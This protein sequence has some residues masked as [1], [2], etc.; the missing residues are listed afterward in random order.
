DKERGVAYGADGGEEK[1]ESEIGKLFAAQAEADKKAEI[2]SI[3]N[4]EYSRITGAQGSRGVSFYYF[5]SAFLVLFIIFMAY[6]ISQVANEKLSSG[7]PGGYFNAPYEPEG[8]AG[9]NYSAAGKYLDPLSALAF[10]ALE[11]AAIFV[12]IIILRFLLSCVFFK[13]GALNKKINIL[14]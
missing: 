1:F 7:G 9:D 8:D 6:N 3:R 14:S 5:L 13:S 12:L 11:G 2:S 10:F 4:I